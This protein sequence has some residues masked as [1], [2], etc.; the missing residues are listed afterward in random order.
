MA[1][2]ESVQ[3]MVAAEL[4]PRLQ[5]IESNQ[6]HR[7]LHVNSPSSPITQITTDLYVPFSP[8][9]EYDTLHVSSRVD[10][11][12]DLVAVEGLFE[13]FKAALTEDFP[14]GRIRE[15]HRNAAM[16]I[17]YASRLE[18][19]PPGIIVPELGGAR[20]SINAALGYFRKSESDYDYYIVQKFLEQHAHVLSK[21]IAVTYDTAHHNNNNLIESGKIR[22]E[23][24]APQINHPEDSCE[25]QQQSDKP[26]DHF[27]DFVGI[28]HIV[29]RL[30]DFVDTADMS[31]E[32]LK[33]YHMR[34]N[35]KAF[36]LN[37]PP[38]VGKTPLME[39]FADAL[40]ADI[41]YA[42]FAKIRGRYVGD[43][44]GNIDKIFTDAYASKI[45]TVIIFDEA[46]GSFGAG[47][48]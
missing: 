4:A 30:C 45:R 27:E 13:Q 39:A 32:E 7:I 25:T 37:G 6:A 2:D 38:G 35:N 5:Y 22:F 9:T 33:Q 41:E 20:L 28:D 14:S 44:A 16:Y 8:Q 26:I 31:L 48:E 12:E 43:W 17:D 47:N 10:I 11:N 24:D 46:E 40:N 18:H 1:F 23:L 36:L 3:D 19:A 15:N 34:F 21:I 29:K 42:T